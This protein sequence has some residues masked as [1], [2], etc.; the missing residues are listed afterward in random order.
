LIIRLM[1]ISDYDEVYSL[2]TGT[3]GMGMRSLD[4]SSEGIERFLNRNPSSSF[5]AIEGDDY[6]GVILS[7][8][9]G[10]RGY[11]YHA[12]VKLEYRG[13]G[14]GSRLVDKVLEALKEEGINKVA[15][16]VFKAN[17]IGNAF[18]DGVGFEERTDLSYRNRSINPDN[19]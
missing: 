2:W 13:R 7:G 15:L 19:I 14:I 12:A 18:W 11:I 3:Q 17:E 4:D 9:D 5:V 16:V 1:T 10:R 6:V 8:N